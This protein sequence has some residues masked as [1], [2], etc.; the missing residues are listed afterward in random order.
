MQY[1]P[2]STCVIS[3]IFEKLKFN[4]HTIQNKSVRLGKIPRNV[5][6]CSFRTQS[7]SCN[8]LPSLLLTPILLLN[9]RKIFCPIL[10]FQPI[11]LLLLQETRVFG[12]FGPIRSPFGQYGHRGG[13]TNGMSVCLSEFGMFKPLLLFYSDKHTDIPFGR[14]PL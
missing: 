6:V 5:F 7:N 14:P 3:Q 2:Q 12:A 11:L 1:Q 4:K 13:Q 9:F 10:L 8:F